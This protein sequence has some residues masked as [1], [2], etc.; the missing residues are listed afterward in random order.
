[1]NGQQRKMRSAT[2]CPANAGRSASVMPFSFM[3]AVRGYAYCAFY[4]SYMFFAEIRHWMQ[5]EAAALA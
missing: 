4:Y 3:N 5:P 2:D 1:M